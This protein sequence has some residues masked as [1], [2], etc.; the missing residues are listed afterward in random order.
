VAAEE[1]SVQKPPSAPN[2]HGSPGPVIGHLETRG[3]RI[4]IHGGKDEGYYTVK[5]LDG[6]VLAE[7]LSGSELLSNFPYLH[8]I[9]ENA[10]AGNDASLGP[11][12]QQRFGVDKVD[13]IKLPASRTKVIE[14][15]KPLENIAP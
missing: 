7:N 5:S 4:T 11:G 3:K 8:R 1:E 9:V 10:S 12:G 2:E 13:R 14:N 15:N 6:K